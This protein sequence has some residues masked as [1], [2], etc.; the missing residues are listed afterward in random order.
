[1]KQQEAILAKDLLAV[2]ITLEKEYVKVENMKEEITG[3]NWRKVAGEL[4]SSEL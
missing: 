1:M 3:K 4:L 2:K